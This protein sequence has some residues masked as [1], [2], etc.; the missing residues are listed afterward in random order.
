MQFTQHE[1]YPFLKHY[2]PGENEL[3]HVF[4]ESECYQ[5]RI[6]KLTTS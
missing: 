3:R 5:M 6:L 1:L 2:T 4:F